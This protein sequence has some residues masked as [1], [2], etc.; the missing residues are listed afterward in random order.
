MPIRI[1]NSLTR[2]KEELM[3]LDGKTVR[4]YTCG[5]T[6]YERCHIG[7]ARSLYV[8]DMIRR[9]LKYRGYDVRFVRNITDVDD[10]I[11]HKAKETGR[12]FEEVVGGN[13]E[14]YYRDLEGLGVGKAD[15]EPRA[16]EN[17]PDMI[18]EIESLME[19]GFAYEI[20]G[21][22]YYDVRRF[23]DYGRLS[24]QSIEK[25]EEAVRIEQDECKRDPLD[26]ALWKKAGEGEPF[27]DSPWGKGRPGW[28]MECS[29]MS[30]K[31]LHCETLD[32]HGGG[33]DLIF[34]HHENEIAQAEPLTRKPF[35]RC[36]VHHG[37]LTING[38]KMAKS[39]GNFVTVQDAL[40]R[41]GADDLKLFF[42]SSHYANPVDFSEKKMGDA[43][44]QKESFGDFFN[45]V[46]TWRL[47]E[48]SKK[49][50]ASDEETDKISAL[51]RRFR[52]SMDD[53]FNTPEALACMFGLIDLGA[54]FI[55]ADKED[56]FRKVYRCLVE[57]FK[58][59]GLNVKPAIEISGEVQALADR[60]EQARKNRDFRKADALRDEMRERYSISAVDTAGGITFIEARA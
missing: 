56:A 6:V 47:Y 39:L 30:L 46:E 5:V 53:D 34:P 55:C 8:F 49:A 32:I 36:W 44:K 17:I 29:C 40:N 18:R 12:T 50:A 4:M 27:W 21:N 45:K 60:R 41:Y 52:E 15:A 9:Y 58:V 25:M 7:H 43:K 16:T 57:Y 54:G 31:H 48:G 22:V 33:R 23:K 10:K 14:A 35:S 37:L 19:K 42:L 1:Y 20:D 24:G 13:I 59:F 11:I 3:P 26:F 38:Q 28:H 51:M 2:K